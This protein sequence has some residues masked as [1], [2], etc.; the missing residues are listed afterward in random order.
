M[1]YPVALGDVQWAREAVHGTDL[2]ATSKMLA[3]EFSFG[4]DSVIERPATARGLLLR[5]RGHEQAVKY[6]TTWSANGPLSYEQAQH[7]LCMAVENVAAPTGPGPYVWDHIR[8]IT[9]FPN[10]ASFTIEKRDTD[11]TTPIVQVAHYAMLSSLTLSGEPNALTRFEAEGFARKLTTAEAF[12]AALTTPTPEFG[13]FALSKVYIDDTWATLGATQVASQVIGWNTEILTGAMPRFTADG[14]TELDFNTHEINAEEV[15]INATINCL[16][17]PQWAAESA[18][19][20][21]GTLRAVRIQI[22]GSSDREII[23]DF[24]AK[25]ELPEIPYDGEDE[26]QRTASLVMLDST[27]QTNFLRIQVTNGVATLI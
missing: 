24:L 12:T 18:A 15:G 7:W 26:G 14:R 17:G 23:I 19:A 22:E 27:D 8:P 13:P 4:S 1:P 3:E 10:L 6:G 5:N 20:A 2:P 11:G 21:A 25:Y 16:L 9:D